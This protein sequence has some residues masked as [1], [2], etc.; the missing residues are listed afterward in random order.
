[1]YCNTNFVDF[2]SNINL[3]Q[4]VKNELMDQYK[5]LMNRLRSEPIGEHIIAVFLQGSVARDTAI[6]S[7]NEDK[8]DIDIVVVTDFV[9][10]DNANNTDIYK[11]SPE[12]ALNAFR[13]FLNKYYSG[14]WKK[15]GR[16][17]GIEMSN[18]CIDLVPTA[19]PSM[20]MKKFLREVFSN[21]DAYSKEM[22]S[23]SYV[24][25]QLVNCSQK[26]KAWKNDYLMIPDREAKKWDKTHPLEQIRWAN[27][28][29]GSTNYN[30]KKVVRSLKWWN[31]NF[32]DIDGIKSYPLEHFIGECCPD[33][34]TFNLERS[35]YESI[36]AMAEYSP[37]KPYM[38]D[39][40]VAEHDVFARVDE[41]NYQEFIKILKVVAKKAKEAYFNEDKKQSSLL[42]REIF[43]TEF[44]VY[45]TPT[46]KFTEREAA[47]KIDSQGRFAE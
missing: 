27:E 7:I 17:L 34:K 1:M 35:V 24:S 10:T 8:S 4:H 44:P 25:Q 21:T 45:E 23:E 46:P 39:R 33:N 38:A 36:V 22:F 15:Q 3:R 13:P 42:W 30:Y 9:C 43:G 11:K 14:K 20:E 16:S 12:Q 32:V 28:K 29:H 6:K 2:V 47:S 19:L 5:I 40:G 31:K 37:V 41:T 18:C 26:N